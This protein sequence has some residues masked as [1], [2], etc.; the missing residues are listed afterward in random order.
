MLRTLFMKDTRILRQKLDATSFRW[1]PKFDEWEKNTLHWWYI[2][3]AI[4]FDAENREFVKF[5]ENVRC[6]DVRRKDKKKKL[7]HRCFPRI[8]SLTKRR[9]LINLIIFFVLGRARKMIATNWF[10]TPK[11]K[12]FKWE[13]I[14][15]M[16]MDIIHWEY[17]YQHC[18][19]IANPTCTLYINDFLI[20]FQ[21]KQ[22]TWCQFFLVVTLRLL[23]Y[24]FNC[25]LHLMRYH[26]NST[27]ILYLR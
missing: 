24:L 4:T 1:H 11:N 22:K 23:I 19:C 12:T 26:L 9:N 17:T 16:L 3:E 13:I 7:V 27:G 20:D 25:C 10:V 2:R 15:W 5:H 21:R 14:F 8:Q 18:K 6:Q